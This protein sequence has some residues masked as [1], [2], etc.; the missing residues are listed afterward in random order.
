MRYLC[1]TRTSGGPIAILQQQYLP[2]WEA[3]E[4]Y[5]DIIRH[6]QMARRGSLQVLLDFGEIRNLCMFYHESDGNY[7]VYHA[8]EEFA[9]LSE[10]YADK[11]YGIDMHLPYVISSLRSH[12]GIL[13]SCYGGKIIIFDAAISGSS[14]IRQIFL[15]QSQP[16]MRLASQGYGAIVV[17]VSTGTWEVLELFHESQ[18]VA[19]SGVWFRKVQ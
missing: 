13:L 16:E 2:L 3:K 11:G 12:A 6:H 17:E 15:Q 9:V 7:C 4:D 19:F 18:H 8:P 10:I 5:F 1:E 14:I